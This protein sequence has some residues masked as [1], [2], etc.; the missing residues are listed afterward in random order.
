[1]CETTISPFI[2]QQPAK[3][4]SKPNLFRQFPYL[5]FVVVVQCSEKFE[6]RDLDTLIE[7]LL[8][9]ASQCSVEEKGLCLL[10]ASA[11]PKF[12]NTSAALIGVRPREEVESPLPTVS[13]TCSRLT[14]LQVSKNTTTSVFVRISTALLEKCSSNA[15]LEGLVIFAGRDSKGFAHAVN[16]NHEQGF[17]MDHSVD[18]DMIVVTPQKRF[19][20]PITGP[21]PNLV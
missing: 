14:P 1:M 4:D 6:T 13:L 19:Y 20:I 10:D 5:K 7:R 18:Y 15:K 3:Q 12:M 11:D 8:L 2:S 17:A 9:I 16:Q 21:V